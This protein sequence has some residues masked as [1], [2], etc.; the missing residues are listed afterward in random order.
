MLLVRDICPRFVS[1][2]SNTQ[3]LIDN[4]QKK[5]L[6]GL[7]GAFLGALISISALFWF[8]TLNWTFVALGAGACAIL[9]FAW[10]EPFLE[11]LQEV[12]WWS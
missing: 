8:S 5:L 11:W 2:A 6:H 4:M 12:F 3:E 10:G 1:A 7:L 9:S